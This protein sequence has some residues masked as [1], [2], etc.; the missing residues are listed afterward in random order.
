MVIL[1]VYLWLCIADIRGDHDPGYGQHVID[2]SYDL[3]GDGD[4]NRGDCF[5]PR[6]HCDVGYDASFGRV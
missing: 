3:L 6:G 2:D 4:V 1:V 5:G